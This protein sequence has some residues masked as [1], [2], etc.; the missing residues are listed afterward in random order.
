MEPVL[1][2]ADLDTWSFKGTALAVLGHPIKHSISPPMH[3]AALAEMANSDDRFT[4]WRYFRFDVPPADLSLALDR[5]HAA[6]FHGLNLTVPHKVLAFDTIAQ[7]DP[8][9]Q[10]IGAVNTLQR[11]AAG[12]HGY[13]TDGYGLATA[14]QETLGI[15][16]FDTPIVLLGAGG[17]ARGAAVEC[18]AQG[19]ASLHIVNRTT[20]N[21]EALL[22][23]LA[24]LAGGIPLQG[25]IPA[26]A[27]VINATSAGLKPDDPL[28]VDLTTLPRPVGVFDMIYNPA[29]TPLLTAAKTHAIPTAN[30]LA[31]LVHQGARSLEIWSNV[32]VPVEAMHA[33]VTA[34]IA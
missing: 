2:L 34:A 11:T 19:C 1:T 23:Q 9:A 10:P 20:A 18:L 5:L 4:T 22:S 17:A 28:P 26:E 29:E 31:M 16:L 14:V 13:N 30:G 27:L 25:E 32:A 12:W 3:N 24:P 21:R 8:T 7:V 33:A 6:G 15:Q